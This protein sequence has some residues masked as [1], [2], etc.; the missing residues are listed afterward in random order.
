MISSPSEW[1]LPLLPK[2]CIV[3]SKSGKQERGFFHPPNS[4]KIRE[5]FI[6]K[7]ALGCKG[8]SLGGLILKLRQFALV[9]GNGGALCLHFSGACLH[10]NLINIILSGKTCCDWR[11][12]TCTNSPCESLLIAQKG[13][14]KVLYSVGLT[15][16]PASWHQPHLSIHV[17]MFGHC[18]RSDPHRKTDK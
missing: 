8:A 15:L 11:A 18:S 10:H 12:N 4:D 14:N 5:C 17:F 2:H 1:L 9:I 6:Y 13:I 16:W 7:E 3:T